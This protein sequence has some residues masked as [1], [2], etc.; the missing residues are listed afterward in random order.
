[1]TDS[2]D[3]PISSIPA[4]IQIHIKAALGSYPHRFHVFQKCL[5][6]ASEV[7]SPEE[8]FR[9]WTS[10]E[11]SLVAFRQCDTREYPPRSSGE[12]NS[13]AH[14]YTVR[15]IFVLQKLLQLNVDF[16]SLFAVRLIV[17]TRSHREDR[18]SQRYANLRAICKRGASLQSALFTFFASLTP[19]HAV[20][21]SI[22]AADKLLSS[23]NAL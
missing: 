23:G 8:R 16:V 6:R 12:A 15:T 19:D 5:R 1:M 20:Q 11:F 22:K 18:V 10:N 13:T 7:F 14:W 3:V 21:F 2:N 9:S 17:L 4:Y